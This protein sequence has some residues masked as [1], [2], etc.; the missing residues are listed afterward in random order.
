[1]TDQQTDGQTDREREVQGL[2]ATLF[3][4]YSF[5]HGGL[6]RILRMCSYGHL[7]DHL[8]DDLTDRQTDRQTDS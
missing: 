7:I 2:T 8:T 3:I 6:F 4:L 5:V 1:M